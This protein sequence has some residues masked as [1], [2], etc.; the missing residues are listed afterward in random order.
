MNIIMKKIS[1]LLLVLV[2]LLFI[3]SGC[4]KKETGP[5]YY[6]KAR[7]GNTDY[8]V[9]GCIAFSSGNATIFKGSQAQVTSAY[10]YIAL[11]IQ[12]GTLLPEEIKF[13]KVPG[14]YANVFN[15]SGTSSVA[16]NG[17]VTITET[18]G[19]SISGTFSFTCTDG[20]TVT[21]GEFTAKRM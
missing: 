21:D 16:Q 3:L 5:A 2:A 14:S 20:T 8:N 19:S 15:A 11:S 18:T 17:T 6:I 13:V 12:K 4:K 1:A 7:V 9:P 10:A